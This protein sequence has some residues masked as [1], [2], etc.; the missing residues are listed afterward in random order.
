MLVADGGGA[1]E[2]LCRSYEVSLTCGSLNI[3]SCVM[4]AECERLRG[5]T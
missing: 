2:F 5:S 4:P 3:V 1:V